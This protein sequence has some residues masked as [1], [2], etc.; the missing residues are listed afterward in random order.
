MDPV[1]KTGIQEGF[2]GRGSSLLDS[3]DS[4]DMYQ[5]SVSKNNGWTTV[6]DPPS[7]TT[8]VTVGWVFRVCPPSSRRVSGL[9]GLSR[10]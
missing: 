2:H 5:E 4:F 6:D 8:E 3:S 1:T 9:L 7:G 10:T